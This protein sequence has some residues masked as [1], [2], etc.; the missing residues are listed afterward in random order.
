[1]PTLAGRYSAIRAETERLAAPLSAEDQGAQ[2]MED[3]SPAKWHRAHT[4]WFFETFILLQHARDYRPY[5]V[6]YSRLFN[7][8]YEAIGERHARHRRGLLTRPSVVQIA[9]YRRHVDRA[10]RDFLV[11]EPHETIRSPRRA[12]IA[13]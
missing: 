1:M 10:M 6:D 3:A 8:Y 7:S 9:E 2:S 4:T 11:A 13:A 5:D 12:R